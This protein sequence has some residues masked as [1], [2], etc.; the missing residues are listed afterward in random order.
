MS[1][2]KAFLTGLLCGGAVAA[3]TVLLAAPSSGKDFR[4]SIKRKSDDL[5]NSLDEIKSD[6]I[7][8]KDQIIQTAEESKD[9]FIELKNDIQKTFSSWK[10]ETEPNK[11]N[12]QKEILEIQQSLD[13][14]Q[15]NIIQKN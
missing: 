12:I 3:V 5:K 6:S 14:L 11:E 8:L 1:N 10:Q 15:K 13:S 7:Q 9:V 2:Y 4:Y